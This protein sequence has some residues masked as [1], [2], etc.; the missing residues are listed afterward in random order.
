MGEHKL[1][2]R[3]R[4]PTFQPAFKVDWTDVGQTLLPDETV[5]FTDGSCSESG[6]GIGVV[7]RRRGAV[8]TTTKE[9]RVSDHATPK[10]AEI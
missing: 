6:N 4:D 9:G 8:D 3:W 2:D 5:A 10:Q 1:S 7:I